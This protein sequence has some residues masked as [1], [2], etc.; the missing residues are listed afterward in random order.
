MRAVPSEWK[1]EVLRAARHCLHASPSGMSVG[2]R[3]GGNKRRDIASVVG[4]KA[5]AAIFPIIPRSSPLAGRI[6]STI[7]LFDSSSDTFA[8][9]LTEFLD[10]VAAESNTVQRSPRLRPEKYQRTVLSRQNA[11]QHEDRE[12]SDSYPASYF[13]HCFSHVPRLTKVE[14]Q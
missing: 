3:S 9:T 4:L 5:A 14:R 10:M 7:L 13:P 6:E 12:H 1:L 11:S 8:Q 2:W